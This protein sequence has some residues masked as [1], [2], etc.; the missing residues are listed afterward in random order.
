MRTILTLLLICM[1]ACPSCT[2]KLTQTPEESLKRDFPRIKYDSLRPFDIKGI[3]EGNTENEIFYYVPEMGYL[4][5]GEIITKDGRSLT[6]ERLQEIIS[7]RLREKIKEIP[8]D[9]AVS[10][11]TGKHRVIEIT[12][13]DCP[14]CRKVSEFFS[15]RTDVTRYVFFNPLPFHPKAEGKVLYILCAADRVKAY[16]E[17]MTGRLDEGDFK[18]CEDAKIKELLETHKNIANLM[19]ISGTP[20]FFIDGKTAVFGADIPKLEKLLQERQ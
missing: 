16:E 2:P 7:Q 6:R 18:I 11:G 1:L 10:I 5:I 3:Y 17:A 19:G 13:P 8:L 12:D 4:F 20:F 14:Y 15:Q 9:K